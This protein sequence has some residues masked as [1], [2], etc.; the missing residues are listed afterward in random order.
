VGVR[1]PRAPPVRQP[2]AAAPGGGAA[3]RDLRREPGPRRRRRV[4]PRAGQGQR[5]AQ[6]QVW[7]HVE[8]HA[9]RHRCQS[10]LQSGGE[11]RTRS[12]VNQRFVFYREAPVLMEGMACST[13]RYRRRQQHAHPSTPGASSIP[14][15]AAADRHGGKD[16]ARRPE[17]AGRFSAGCRRSR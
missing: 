7:R 13:S 3:E 1:S 6:R 4:E 11:R 5:R 12:R 10:R 14:T 2:R 8:R 17:R 15:G 16:D 9:R